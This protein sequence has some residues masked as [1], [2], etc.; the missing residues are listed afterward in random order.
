MF[1]DQISFIQFERNG[2]VNASILNNQHDS[3]EKKTGKLMLMPT[4]WM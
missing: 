4:I 3:T 2:F 1:Y